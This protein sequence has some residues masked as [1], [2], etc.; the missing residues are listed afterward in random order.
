MANDRI[1][2]LGERR[3]RVRLVLDGEEVAIYGS[4]QVKASVFQQPAAFSLHLGWSKVAR[5]LV[6]KYPEHTP[7]EL[8]VGD[9]KVQVGWTD[10]IEPS[11][12]KNGS[13]IQI[14]GRD[15]LAPVF[16]GYITAER[17]FANKSYLELTLEALDAVGLG[18]RTVIAGNE[19]NR[20][21][22]S[23]GRIRETGGGTAQLFNVI[24]ETQY[25]VTFGSTKKIVLHTL[26][27][28]LGTRWFEFL[29]TEL[30]KVGL[31]LWAGVDGSFILARPTADQSP[32]AR[33]VR[34]RGTTRDV[35]NVLHAR[36]RRN[37]VSRYTKAVVYGRGGGG[38]FGRRK[39]KGEYVDPD[40][41]AILGGEDVKQIVYHEENVVSVKAANFVARRK[42]A[43][44]NR[45]SVTLEYKV[46]GHTTRGLNGEER[47]V[48]TPDTV[49]DVDDDEFGIKGPY[50][51]SDV[52]YDRSPQTTTTLTLMR[53]QDLVFGEDPKKAL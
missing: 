42:I 33:L 38:K 25:E 3:D 53:P 17:S 21:A 12:D 16:D 52:S 43:E 1:D 14:E 45:A 26:K 39:L 4:Y 40:M 24:T 49:I 19:A 46:S 36:W 23:G 31:F 30:K 44:T 41:A 7:F 28:K 51:L 27:A 18:D 48:W 37:I 22:I 50:Y 35:S 32:V 10:G 6:E 29:Q 47:V 5:E 2:E 11:S 9:R 20:K 15:S 8:Y 34:R 13:D